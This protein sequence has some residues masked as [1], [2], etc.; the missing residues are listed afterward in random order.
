MSMFGHAV[1]DGVVEFSD[2][3]RKKRV[4]ATASSTF[5]SGGA[6]ACVSLAI[7]VMMSCCVLAKT[8]VASLLAF[9]AKNNNSNNKRLIEES[10][11]RMASMC[12]QFFGGI[13]IEVAPASFLGMF[14]GNEDEDSFAIVKASCSDLVTGFKVAGSLIRDL[15]YVNG[16]VVSSED[17]CRRASVVYGNISPDGC[18]GFMTDI[19]KH[20]N[21]TINSSVSFSGALMRE[22]AEDAIESIGRMVMK[23]VIESYE[24]TKRDESDHMGVLEDAILTGM[25]GRT[26]VSGQ[27]ARF[28]TGIDNPEAHAAELIG[29]GDSG[30][31][32]RF[33]KCVVGSCLAI[34]LGCKIAR[35]LVEDE[36]CRTQASTMFAAVS[37]L[38]DGTTKGDCVDVGKVHER[39][40]YISKSIGNELKDE[41]VG[42]FM[43]NAAA[44][45][46]SAFAGNC[47]INGISST[48]DINIEKECD[49]ESLPNAIPV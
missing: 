8:R 14:T 15:F 26:R 21:D 29:S 27:I 5:Y 35:R 48:L 34:N 44:A 28:V 20:V 33:A 43:L 38:S 17:L 30:A 7:P 9:S 3:I 19:E 13:G 4:T 12:S 24:W 49:D 22:S 25:V 18:T 2:L 39:A 1:C 42:P 37:I 40:L 45:F 41:T 31:T 6:T 36:D 32:N 46:I 47:L 23:S 16:K 11:N 10:F